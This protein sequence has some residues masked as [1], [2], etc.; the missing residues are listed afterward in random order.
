MANDLAI[1]VTWGA[2]L[3]DGNRLKNLN[4]MS[5]G[6]SRPRRGESIPRHPLESWASYGATPPAP[7]IVGV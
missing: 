4:L 5:I 3:F 2:F 1:L 6:N 7:A